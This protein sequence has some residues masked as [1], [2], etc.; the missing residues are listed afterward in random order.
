MPVDNNVAPW[1]HFMW[2]TIHYVALG[3]PEQPSEED[4][5]NY[6]KYFMSI[7]PIIPCKLCTDHFSHLISEQEPLDSVALASRES[8]FDWTVRV[9]NVV[10]ARLNKKSWTTK[11]AQLYFVNLKSPLV[12]NRDLMCSSRSWI[13]SLILLLAVLILI[14]VATWYYTKKRQ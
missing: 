14:A 9:H 5:L 13:F 8:L 12:E 11:D 10:N 7:G 6:S 3:Y 1:G 4:K 2:H